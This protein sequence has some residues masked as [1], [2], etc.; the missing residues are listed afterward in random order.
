MGALNRDTGDGQL[1]VNLVDNLR[2]DHDY[3]VFGVVVEGMAWVASVQEGV[4]IRSARW[5]SW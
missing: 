2:L 3:T 1:F 4:R 5:M